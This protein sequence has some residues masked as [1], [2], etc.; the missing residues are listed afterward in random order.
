MRTL[1]TFA[2]AMKQSHLWK[3]AIGK[4]LQMIKDCGVFE[5]VDKDKVPKNKNIIGCRWVYTNKFNAD[6]EVVQQKVCLVAKGYLQVAGEDFN[7]TYVAVVH[8]ESLR[9]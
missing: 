8:L 2:E 6:V 4:E 1:K 7:E 9:M 5:L 3:P